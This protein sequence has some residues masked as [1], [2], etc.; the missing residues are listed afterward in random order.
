MCTECHQIAIQ[1]AQNPTLCKRCSSILTDPEAIKGLFSEYGF[2]HLVQDDLRL[3]AERGCELCRMFLLQDPNTDPRRLQFVP[4]F[5]VG[6]RSEGAEFKDR[7]ESASAGDINS[8][9]FSSETDQFSLELSVS[10]YE[11]DPAS[12]YIRQRPPEVDLASEHT[13]WQIRTWLD[14]C[15]QKHPESLLDVELP[16]LPTR[17][18][19]V[20]IPENKCVKLFEPPSDMRQHYLTLSYCWGTQRFLTTTTANI[21]A[22]K[23]KL[24]FPTLPQTFQDAIIT[25]RNL[26]FRYIWIDALCIIQDSNEDKA[27][28]INR[29]GDIYNDSFLTIGVVAATR[30]ADGFLKPKPQKAVMLPYRCPD[31]TMGSVRVAPQ[32][33]VDLWQESLYTRGWCLQENLLSRRLLLYTDTEVIWQCESAP[34]RRVDTAHVSYL[35]DLP[36]L[37]Q[38]PFR[39]LP[40]DVLRTAPENKGGEVDPA[41]EVEHY[42][43]WTSIVANYTRRRLTVGADRLPALGGIA[44]KFSKAWSDEYFAGHWK[45]QFIAS[46]SWRRSRQ[47]SDERFPPVL[48]YRAPSWSWASIDGP[49]EFDFE[50]NT[51]SKKGLNAKLISV[52]FD[53][54]L[55]SKKEDAAILE[56]SLIPAEKI[57]HPNGLSGPGHSWYMDH[58]AR[59]TYLNEESLKDTWCMLLTEGRVGSGKLIRATALMLR[60]EPDKPDCF[61][62][63]GLFRSDMKGISKLWADLK[64]RRQVKIV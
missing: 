12:T 11:G 57:P 36:K 51:V 29:M 23:V 14:E 6:K 10:A 55:H 44:Q 54:D 59:I 62:R 7:P 30:V 1:A 18:L 40:A 4:L 19:D 20:G 46:L 48:E 17:V 3:H 26:G 38:S 39:R 34:M 37:R 28:E 25:T 53:L 52:A 5:L 56:A 41:M 42:N 63:A 24:D 32:K 9:Y 8:F 33:V 58:D 45:R 31:G 16:H 61:Y 43:I 13:N 22:H 60:A 15:I 47:I 35:Y 49:V 27:K 2:Q 21:E 64:T 50:S